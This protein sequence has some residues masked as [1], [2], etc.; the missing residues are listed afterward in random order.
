MVKK[1]FPSFFAMIAGLIHLTATLIGILVLS[2]LPL[3]TIYYLIAYTF[4]I[5]S[6]FAVMGG[7]LLLYEGILCYR[8]Q[9]ILAKKW[10]KGGVILGVLGLG[11]S[12]I[13]LTTYGPHLPAEIGYPT[14]II[15]T[16]LRGI[17]VQLSI[18][19]L[20]E[21]EARKSEAETI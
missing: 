7:V 8:H 20:G 1:L 10:I 13:E 16:A 21:A 14:A 3:E 12:I 17:G 18:I 5:E 4:L 11:V 19:A 6:I 2:L 15:L 9:G